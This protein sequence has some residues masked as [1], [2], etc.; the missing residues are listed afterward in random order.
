M[1]GHVY[2]VPAEECQRCCAEWEVELSTAR[3][4]LHRQERDSLRMLVAILMSLGGTLRLSQ[5]TVLEV[6]PRDS[7][8]RTDAPETA[9]IVFR[10]RRAGEPPEHQPNEE[11]PCPPQP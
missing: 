11:D 1:T 4:E 10:L 2:P 5:R 8:S 7:V 6:D 3:A 9:E